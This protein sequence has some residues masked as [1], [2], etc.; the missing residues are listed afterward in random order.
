MKKILVC[1]GYGSVGRICL[2]SLKKNSSYKKIEIVDIPNKFTKTLLFNKLKKFGNQNN[3]DVIVGFANISNLK[4]NEQIFKLVTN[5]KYNI[6]NVFHETSIIDKDVSFGKG[7]KVFPGVI[8]NRGC[9]IKN[10][11]LINTGAIIEHDCVINEHA[12]ISPGCI[13]AGNVIIGKLSFIGM[14]TKI[15]QGVKIGKNSIVGAGSLVLKDI[16]N[17]STFFGSP[18]I[19]IK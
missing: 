2:D 10:N 18:A 4:K 5:L 11:V 9:K 13:L 19:E 3:L 16:P 14:G 8:I 1:I 6:I 15:I 12:Q 7:A 17:N